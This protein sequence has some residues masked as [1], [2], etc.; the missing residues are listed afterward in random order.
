MG[1]KLTGLLLITASL[2]GTT[3]KVA[4]SE[5]IIHEYKKV[6]KYFATSDD[7][8][9]S[10]P[11]LQLGNLQDYPVSDEITGPRPRFQAVAYQQNVAMG[12]QVVGMQGMAPYGNAVVAAP[13]LQYVQPQAGMAQLGGMVANPQQIQVIQNQ[14]AMISMAQ[15][16]PNGGFQ[17]IQIPNTMI[18][19]QSFQLV[20]TPTGY[21]IVQVPNAAFAQQ[22]NLQLVQTPNGYQIVQ[23]PNAAYGQQNAYQVVPFQNQAGTAMIAPNGQIQQQSTQSLAPAMGGQQLGYGTPGAQLSGP[24]AGIAAGASIDRGRMII[25]QMLGE[26]DDADKPEAPGKEA[27]RTV[28]VAEPAPYLAMVREAA[29][30]KKSDETPAMITAGKT[31]APIG[32]VRFCRTNQSDCIIRSKNPGIVRLSRSLWNELV[33]V[34]AYVN[35]A[36]EPVTDMDLYNTAEKWAY[37][38]GGKGDCEDYV[39]LKRRLLMERGWP[40]S[41]LL[42]TV[43]RD[44]RGDGHAVLTVRTDEGDFVLDNQEADVLPWYATAYRYVKRQSESD[45][46]RWVSIDDPRPYQVGSR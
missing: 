10:E 27:K 45:T 41:T 11:P 26:G 37:P 36:V 20:Q 3:A 22:N 23:V 14:N 35:A 44:G 24:N 42:I 21:Q 9:T 43:V 15:P 2:L 33:A 12:G 25:E 13:Q 5:E 7:S 17:I 32:F 4:Y 39:L 16:M 34:N 8:I 40:A 28:P 6:A 1:R 18:Q 19:P 30:S 29:S 38:D 46:S 31:S